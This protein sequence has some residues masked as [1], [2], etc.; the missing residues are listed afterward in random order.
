MA[1]EQQVERVKE[2]AD[3]VVS[4]LPLYANR[5]DV[6]N[7]MRAAGLLLDER[8]QAC[9]E[10][11]VGAS[12]ADDS[13]ISDKLW[14]DSV[15]RRVLRACVAAGAAYDAPRRTREEVIADI[16]IYWR[17]VHQSNKL[18]GTLT[19]LLDELAAL[20]EEGRKP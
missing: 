11:C 19:R 12:R 10:A 2:R 15:A 5:W 3:F 18:E 20:S 17:G 7:A 4:G 9:V 16:A 13:D 8:A 14:R 6:L 1:T